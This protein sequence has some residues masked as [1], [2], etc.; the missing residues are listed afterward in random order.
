MNSEIQTGV[1]VL[2]CQRDLQRRA[3]LGP[4]PATQRVFV[5]LE[6]FGE[7][8]RAAGI[9]SSFAVKPSAS[10]GTEGFI[11]ENIVSEK[12]TKETVKVHKNTQKMF[13]FTIFLDV[14]LTSVG[15]QHDQSPKYQ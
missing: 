3:E 11:T 4:L 15:K 14:Y 8:R 13:F 5:C 6:R 10:G 1:C 7:R 9:T 12:Q 2:F